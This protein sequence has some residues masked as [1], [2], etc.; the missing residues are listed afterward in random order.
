MGSAVVCNIGNVVFIDI[1]ITR[2]KTVIQ[3]YIVGE[4]GITHLTTVIN[5]LLG[6]MRART[7]T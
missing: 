1:E 3:I 6:G 2:F 5:V 7:N 4:C